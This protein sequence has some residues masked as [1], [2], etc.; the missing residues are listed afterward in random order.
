MGSDY[1]TPTQEAIDKKQKDLNS[2]FQEKT[3]Q[4]LGEYITLSCPECGAEF[5]VK[6]TDIL[7]RPE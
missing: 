5:S 6:R 7:T 1:T 4:V 2:K 3:Q